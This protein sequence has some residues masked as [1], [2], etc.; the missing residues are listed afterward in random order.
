MTDAATVDQALKGNGN[1]Y[2]ANE[3]VCSLCQKADGGS[4]CDPLCGDGAINLTLGAA[5]FAT[6]AALAF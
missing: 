2:A 1:P 5:I 6:A 3:K 4:N